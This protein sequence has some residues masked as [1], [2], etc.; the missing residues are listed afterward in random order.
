[1]ATVKNTDLVKY[2]QKAEKEK[3]G[4][5]WGLNGTLYTEELAK[6]YKAR[7]RSTSKYRDPETYWTVDCKR[8]FGK[9]AADCSGGIVGAIRTINPSYGD[10]SANSF[11]AQFT[12]KGKIG[13]LPEISGLALWYDGHIG[14]Y[15]GNGYALEF[16]GTEYGCVRTKVKGRGW[17][18]WGK[19]K[20]VQYPSATKVEKIETWTVTRVLKLTSP[21]Q[22]GADVKA[23]QTRLNAA[24]FDCGKVDGIFG[25]KTD[26]AVRRYQESNKL[27]VDG[28]AGKNTIKSLGGVFRG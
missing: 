28:K 27:V 17:K 4:Y 22:T 20:G 13:T 15:E 18:Y 24:G 7:K 2:F 14:I 25:K 1:M 9:M 12:E 21:M 8:W 5:V 6:Q 16:R 10:R 19:I 23:L 26:K 11:K 3:W